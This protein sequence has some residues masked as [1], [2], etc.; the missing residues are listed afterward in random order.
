M[1]WQSHGSFAHDKD[2]LVVKARELLGIAAHLAGEDWTGGN[3][4]KRMEWAFDALH[5]AQACLATPVAAEPS[6]N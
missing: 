6:T 1:E 4:E 2:P 3:F 5:L